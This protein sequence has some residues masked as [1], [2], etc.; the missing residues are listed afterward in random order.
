MKRKSMFLSFIAIVIAAIAFA[1]PA[2]G[3]TVQKVQPKPDKAIAAAPAAAR[4]ILAAKTDK[5][6]AKTKKK[7]VKKETK[8]KKT[9]TGFKLKPTAPVM[10]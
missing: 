9:G 1:L 7:A 2:A 5:A 6:K 10:A 3:A 4:F 8:P